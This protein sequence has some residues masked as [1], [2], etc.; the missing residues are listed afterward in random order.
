MESDYAEV[1]AHYEEL[2]LEVS[3]LESAT[4]DISSSSDI[5]ETIRPSRQG[6]ETLADGIEERYYTHI[7]RFLEALQYDCEFSQSYFLPFILVQSYFCVLAVNS[8][9]WRYL[10]F[11]WVASFCISDRFL[12]SNP[13]RYHAITTIVSR[14]Q[15]G[16][17]FCISLFLCCRKITF[18]FY[19]L[20]DC[21][22][23]LPQ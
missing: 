22:S 5:Y 16:H 20:I 23:F 10:S 17:P 7:L 3:R 6:P 14:F 1:K 15:L 11:A 4:A 9:C 8:V 12:D 18:I 13:E 21:A 19:A 2:K